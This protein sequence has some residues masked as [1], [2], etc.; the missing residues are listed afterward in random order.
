MTLD[1]GVQE[2]ADLKEALDFHLQRLEYDLVRTDAPALQHSL[3]AYFERLV[4][5][6]DRLERGISQAAVPEAESVH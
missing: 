3:N 4:H 6:R 1:L 2:A 5:I